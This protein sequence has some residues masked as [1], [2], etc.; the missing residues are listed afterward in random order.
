[1]DILINSIQKYKS[2]LAKYLQ[3]ASE[4]LVSKNLTVN[5]HRYPVLTYLFS[6]YKTQLKIELKKL[7][8]KSKMNILKET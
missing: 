7:L 6:S 2:Q 3:S 4:K 5:E 1:M 8:H